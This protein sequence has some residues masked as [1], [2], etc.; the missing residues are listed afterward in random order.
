MAL[1]NRPHIPNQEITEKIIAIIA[2]S[3][4]LDASTISRNTVLTDLGLDSFDTIEFIFSIEQHFDIDI[5]YR[6]SEN[7]V[8]EFVTVG[9]IAEAVAKVV[10]DKPS[11]D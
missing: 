11:T 9:E 10:A 6:P 1:D 3:K 8:S 2:E 7:E 5:P 4:A